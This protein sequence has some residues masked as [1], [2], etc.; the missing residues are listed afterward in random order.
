[1]R[2]AG[3]LVMPAGFF[4]VVAALLLFPDATLRLAFILCGLAVEAMGITVA[5]RGHME[6]RG[7]KRG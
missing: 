3:L 5:V 2:L 6:S 4:L 1:M 7:E